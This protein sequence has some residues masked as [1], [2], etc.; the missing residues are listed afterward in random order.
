MI[1]MADGIDHI[2]DAFRR[3]TIGELYDLPRLRRKGQGIDQHTPFRSHN[4]SGI[5]LGV[6]FTS[7]NPGVICNSRA[8][9]R[10]SAIPFVKNTTFVS[11]QL[12]LAYAVARRQ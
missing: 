4:Q 5:D 6:E 11:K 3:D 2:F 7:E 8:Y 1:G 9:N 12:I 10:H